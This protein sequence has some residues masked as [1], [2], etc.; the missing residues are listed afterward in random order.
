MAA[1]LEALL[2][3]ALQSRADLRSGEAAWRRSDLAELAQAGAAAGLATYGGQVQARRGGDLTELYWQD[4]DPAPRRDGEA[5]SAFVTRSWQE[6][7]FLIAA[8]PSD[9]ELARQAEARTEDLWFV[10]YLQAPSV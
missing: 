8:L 10:V 7:L 1:R 6:L 9:E 3:P 2:P 5:F 4:Y